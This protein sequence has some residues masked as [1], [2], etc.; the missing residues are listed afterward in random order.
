VAENLDLEDRDIEVDSRGPVDIVTINRP[1]TRNAL[2]YETYEQLVDAIE[3]SSARAIVITGAGTSFCSGDD[4][5]AIMEGGNRTTPIVETG[6]ADATRALLYTNIPV[7]GAING[8]AV[9]W[10]MELAIMCDLR[11]AGVSARFGELFVLRGLCSDVAGLGR[12]AQLVGREKAT[13][14]L[15]TGDIISAEEAKA[16]GLVS[17]VVP[18]DETLDAALALATTIAERPPLAVGR[19]KEGLRKA[20]DPDWI[21]MGDWVAKA[22]TELFAT[23]DHREGVKAFVERRPP[24]YVGR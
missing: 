23:E 12:L 17:R 15:L 4:V 16:I 22:L 1:A 8:P 20:L 9:G 14:L 2:R 3:G 6:L 5:R 7:I 19:I 24:K 21:E 13:E 11:V 10:G 18:D